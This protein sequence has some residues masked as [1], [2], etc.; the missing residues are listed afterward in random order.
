MTPKEA[1]KEIGNLGK[2]YA[3]NSREFSAYMATNAA[4]LIKP[5]IHN[6]G[7]DANERPLSGYSVPYTKRR[8]KRGRRTDRKDL[9]FTDRLFQAEQVYNL[10]GVPVFGI[11]P[12]KRSD[13]NVSNQEL[14]GILEEKEKT[15]IFAPSKAEFAKLDKIAIEFLNEKFEDYFE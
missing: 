6:D 3:K 10:L 7:L 12:G 11:I 9:Q 14:A 13:S 15:E 4:A 1:G 5:R 2:I 8:Q